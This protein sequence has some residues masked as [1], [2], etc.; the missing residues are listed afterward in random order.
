M[1]R[2]AKNPPTERDLLNFARE[3]LLSRMPGGWTTQIKPQ[4]GRI[5]AVWTL[6]TPG[7]TT[8]VNCEV[9]SI[10]NARD[11]P[12]LVQRLA[13]TASGRLDPTLVISRYLSPRTREALVAARISYFDATGNVRICLDDP[14]VFIETAGADS[15][16]WRSPD[17]PTNSLRGRPAARVVRALVDLRPPWKV[18]D[19]AAAAGTSLGSTARTL[20]LLSR[21]ALLERSPLGV[22][23]DVAWEPLLERWA[24]ERRID[25]LSQVLGRP[26]R[27]ALVPEAT[28]VGFDPADRIR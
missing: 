18:R 8:R 4:P 11:M 12:A 15:D 21:E 5:D 3:F 13:G 2:N 17:R 16:P 27:L 7:C 9:K 25:S 6:A 10:L 23:V 28:A 14:V 22:V 20:D 24:A 26:V 19:L 1:E